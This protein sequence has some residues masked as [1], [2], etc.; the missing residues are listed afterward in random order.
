MSDFSVVVL[1]TDSY[2]TNFYD[3]KNTHVS[4]ERSSKE[5]GAYVLVFC[6][7]NLISQGDSH[8]LARRKNTLCFLHCSPLNFHTAEIDMNLFTTLRVFEVCIIFQLWTPRQDKRNQ[9]LNFHLN[10]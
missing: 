10:L 2:P 6:Y 8:S 7:V 9:N 1:W 3:L 4:R 5:L